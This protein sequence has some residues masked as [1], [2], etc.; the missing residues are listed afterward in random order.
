MLVEVRVPVLAESVAEATLMD[1]HKQPGDPVKFGDALIDVETDK[2]TLEVVAPEDGMLVKILKNSGEDVLSNELIAEID[3]DSQAVAAAPEPDTEVAP[4]ETEPEQEPEAAAESA[5]KTTQTETEPADDAQQPLKSESG[6]KLSPAVRKLLSEHG[7][8]A[9]D[10]PASGNRLTKK[11]VLD[12]LAGTE[13]KERKT[14][15]KG[16]GAGSEKQETDGKQQD[17]AAVMKPAPK[18]VEQAGGAESKGPGN[19]VPMTRLRRRA[20][21]RLLAAQRENAI[22]TTFNEVNMKPVMDLRNRYKD[23]FEKTHK[24]KLGFMSFFTKAAVEAL[25]KFPIINASVDG[26]DII[27]HDN[28]DIGIAVSSP[29]GLVVPVVRAADILSFAEIEKTISEYG[30]KARDAKLTIEELTGGTF[31]I[32]NGGVFGSLLSTPIINPPQSA[33][34]GMHK[35]EER[36][37]AEDGAVVIRPMMY[38]AL[39]YDHRIIDGREAVSFLVAIKEALEDPSRLLLQI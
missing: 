30:Q 23:S 9:G 20:A 1:W 14:E 10:I 4:I 36:P 35:I 18:P 28:F 8:D 6:P 15:D 34:L 31:T 19:R 3:T 37:V 25:K 32:T 5:A 22:L 13:D 33:I 39:S 17:A 29:R 38:L 2:V 26:A 11:Q 27:Y 12:Y 24:V 16:Q 21:E 7:L